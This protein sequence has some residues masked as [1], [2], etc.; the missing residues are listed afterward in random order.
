MKFEYY[1]AVLNPV[2]SPSEW[3]NW[4]NEQGRKGWDLVTVVP[5]G[6][7]AIAIFKLAV[8]A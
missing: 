4:M 5:S 6:T 1:V 7:Q 3:E 8:P 2:D